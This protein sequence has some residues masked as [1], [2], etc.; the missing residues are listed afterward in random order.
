MVGR[1]NSLPEL[2]EV[3]LTRRVGKARHVACS[4]RLAWLEVGFPYVARKYLDRAGLVDIRIQGLLDDYCS[5]GNSAH[6]LEKIS[7]RAKFWVCQ[8]YLDVWYAVLQMLLG[9][10]D[11][12]L[13]DRS[14]GY[15][16]VS[17]GASPCLEGK[18]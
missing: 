6:H 7:G 15:W 16:V 12:E 2:G 1:E 4:P 8:R 11:P 9:T 3:A 13:F 10:T 17:L 5:D 14:H 18:S